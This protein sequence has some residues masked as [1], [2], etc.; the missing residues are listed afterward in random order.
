M[1]SW[2]FLESKYSHGTFL[3]HRYWPQ[4]LSFIIREDCFHVTN[5]DK[6]CP[7]HM[8]ITKFSCHRKL[9][10]KRFIF[11]IR[12]CLLAIFLLFFFFLS[13]PIPGLLCV[14]NNSEFQ[15]NKRNWGKHNWFARMSVTR[16][17]NESY[18]DDIW[19][20]AI[21]FILFIIRNRNNFYMMR[22]HMTFIVS[23]LWIVA[24][25]LMAFHIRIRW[26]LFW[27]F[28]F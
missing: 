27:C 7:I 22:I 20:D 14:L 6:I 12:L 23:S 25:K 1:I 4:P 5:R 15:K 24:S 17:N 11:N 21:S 16:K 18:N 28:I 10:V 13:T 2:I 26:M 8:R 9:N 3:P 19:A